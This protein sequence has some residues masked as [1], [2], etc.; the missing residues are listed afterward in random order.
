MMSQVIQR[1]VFEKSKISSITT[2]ENFGQENFE[3]TRQ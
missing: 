3:K 2:P 1:K